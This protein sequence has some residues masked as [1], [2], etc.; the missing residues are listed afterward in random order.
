MC[1]LVGVS[2]KFLSK[3]EVTFMEQALYSD[4]LRG[5]HSTGIASM[6]RK[7][8]NKEWKGNVYKRADS[9]M[10]LFNLKA[11]D[12]FLEVLNKNIFNTLM[13]HNRFATLGRII[14]ANA[15]PFSDNNIILAH[16]GTLR[17]W[18]TLPDSQ[19]F[20]V[21][22]ECIAHSIAK[23]GVVETVALLEGAFALSWIDLDKGTLNLI[24]NKERPLSIFLNKQMNKVVWGSESKMME[25]LI[26]RN[27]LDTTIE[28]II[29]PGKWHVFDLNEPDFKNFQVYDVP[30]YKPKPYQSYIPFK[31]KETK[32]TSS[33]S[34]PHGKPTTKRID[35]CK[36]NLEKW[37]LE[38]KQDV[39]MV[40]QEFVPY[41][42]DQPRSTGY[43]EGYMS[44]EPYLWV[45]I[46]GVHSNQ[47]IEGE[48]YFTK[49]IRVS[50]TEGYNVLAGSGMV[51]IND[52][53][54]E[55]K[56]GK[57][58]A[59]LVEKERQ[60]DEHV[61]KQMIILEEQEDKDKIYTDP[62]GNMVGLAEID[63]FTRYGCCA[64]SDHIQVED[65]KDIKWMANGL[66]MCNECHKQWENEIDTVGREN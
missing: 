51:S 59:A 3:K 23:I 55:D 58:L 45:K 9:P 32:S 20:T 29:E 27:D 63:F 44:D 13:G 24:R 17:F 66:P 49:A 46:H 10:N 14:D 35:S 62:H 56:L 19:Y 65:Y 41:Y 16:N 37:E 42:I 25:W 2:G 11:Y 31:K 64:C 52:R 15:H 6:Y 21:D 34:F 4:A 61:L 38:Y 30:L 39:A 40:A 7:N 54:E 53:E 43:V 60:E 22:S 33:S 36:R 26:D 48:E 50:K 18:N 57:E 5:M 12:G 8:V 1:G 28:Y 47:F